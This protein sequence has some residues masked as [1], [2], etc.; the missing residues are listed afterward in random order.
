M[1]AGVLQRLSEMLDGLEPGDL[2]PKDVVPW[3]AFFLGA[4]DVD[5]VERED[6]RDLIHMM[7]LKAAALAALDLDRAEGVR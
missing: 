7:I 3:L 2:E 1:N 4:L 6:A 5:R